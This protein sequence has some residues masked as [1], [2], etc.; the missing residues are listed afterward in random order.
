[1]IA[2]RVTM[3]VTGVTMIVARVTNI[4]ARV[5]VIVNKITALMTKAVNMVAMVIIITCKVH[6]DY[7]PL[8]DTAPL[9]STALK[10]QNRF[11]FLNTE[12]SYSSFRVFST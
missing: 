6:P 9:T 11:V 2:T 3:I 7:S 10:V 5:T 12:I 1:M 8:H 4:V